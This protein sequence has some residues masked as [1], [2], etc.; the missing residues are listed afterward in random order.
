MGGVLNPVIL[1][2][3]GSVITDKSKPMTPKQGEIERLAREIAL[4]HVERLV[5]VHGG[6]SYGHPLA[7]KYKIA[8]GYENRK[9]LL[10]F[11]LTREAMVTL[12]QIVVDQLIRRNVPSVGVQPSAI[13][14]TQ[15][16]R[17]NRIE[18]DPLRRMLELR[19][20]PVLYGDAV[21]DAKLGFTI[22][23]GDQLAVELALSLGSNL[24][25]FGVDVDG[26]CTADPKADPAA[27]LLETVGREQLE[28]MVSSIGGSRTPDVTG[29]MKGK[30][31]EALPLVRRGIKVHIVNACSPENVY[32]ALVG[33]KVRGTVLGDKLE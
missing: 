12:N 31:R 33:R 29:G 17:I 22:L 21:L 1:K 9:Q 7:K 11:S 24:V 4:A 19:L 2:L 14:T 16:G 15:N 26:L 8:E 30:V 3:G 20:V 18:L 32:K 27:R 6:G 13:A 5:I 10:G 23:S 25:V 28:A